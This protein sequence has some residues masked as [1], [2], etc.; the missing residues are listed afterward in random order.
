MF[1]YMYN[2]CIPFYIPYNICHIH[3]Y[4]M[5][6]KMG[7]TYYMHLYIKHYILYAM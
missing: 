5:A 4:Y 2:K 7:C 3:I 1:M 6:C